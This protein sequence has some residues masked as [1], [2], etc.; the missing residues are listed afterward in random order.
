MD[1]T[2][3]SQRPSTPGRY[4]VRH[5]TSLDAQTRARS[6]AGVPQPFLRS[7]SSF[8]HLHATPATSEPM[9]QPRQ[10]LAS[11]RFSKAPPASQEAAALMARVHSVS[12]KADALLVNAGRPNSQ[13]R[14]AAQGAYPTE[15]LVDLTERLA[16]LES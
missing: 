1:W 13:H 12:A 8:G 2:Q 6:P 11:S 5:G 4:A 14:G 15:R 16:R 9:Q 7:S 10:T 3:H